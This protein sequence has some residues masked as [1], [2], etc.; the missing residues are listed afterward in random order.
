MATKCPVQCQRR[1]SLLTQ[2]GPLM[3]KVCMDEFGYRTHYH[4]KNPL[5][6][7]VNHCG[8]ATSVAL[9]TF[10]RRLSWDKL[11]QKSYY[12]P[13]FHWPKGWPLLITLKIIHGGNH[14]IA[15]IFDA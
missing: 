3:A 5:N 13:N 7:N 1:V 6:S 2:N 8:G 14:Q 4:Q 9:S 15:I 10:D 11:L 12:T